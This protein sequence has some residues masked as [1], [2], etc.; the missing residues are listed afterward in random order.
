MAN[1]LVDSKNLY[2]KQHAKQAIAWYPWSEQALRIAKTTDKPI[3][4]S[5]GYA[6]CHWCHMMTEE[7]FN[8]HEVASY[9]NQYFIAIKV[10]REQRP[11]I[12]HVY[13]TCHQL[14]SGQS[15]GWPLNLFLDPKNQV[16]F[17]SGTYFPLTTKYGLP[18]FIDVL[19][20]VHQFYFAHR[21]TIDKQCHR[22]QFELNK[23][24][25][26]QHTREHEVINLSL[27][28][29]RRDY[30]AKIYDAQ[31]GGFGDAPK[32]AQPQF[33]LGLFAHYQQSLSKVIPDEIALAMVEKTLQALG[34]GGLYDHVEGGFFRYSVDAAWHIP[35]FE[36]MLYD[37]ASLL[38]VYSQAYFI[39][40]KPWYRFVA[41]R[42]N[43]WV[44]SY[45]YCQD[46][47]YASSQ[48][49]DSENE[50]GRYYLWS[51]EMLCEAL[52][53]EDYAWLSSYF[54]LTPHDDLFQKIHLQWQKPWPKAV[55]ERE[56][57]ASFYLE[58]QAVMD[59]LAIMRYE[60]KAPAID[61]KLLTSWNALYISALFRASVFLSESSLAKQGLKVL[62]FIET[63]MWHD[64]KLLGYRLE[65][66]TQL[67]FL[68]DYA[69][70]LDAVLLSLQISFNS[71]RWDFALSL[72]EAMITYFYE[73]NTE[74][75]Y[76]T[77]S[78]HHETL[79]YRDF[80]DKDDALPS[81]AAVA[82]NSL[83]TLASWANRPKWFDLAKAALFK[84]WPE[85]LQNPAYFYTWTK[86][87]E[88]FAS[89]LPKLIIRGDAAEVAAWQRVCQAQYW[90]KIDVLAIAN[91]S[92]LPPLWTAYQPKGKVSA[93]YC[94]SKGCLGPFET[95][96]ALQSSI[97]PK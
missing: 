49:A 60:R 62:N 8:D 90:E 4:L 88:R 57:L 65:D 96:T 24:V 64:D 43:Q 78:R 85:I 7:V 12:D 58:Y 53:A 91:E 16:P 41:L 34:H 82:V 11:D 26:K 20:Q 2:L 89:P 84:V 22:L 95:L 69:Y 72:A 9:L 93:W 67:G 48:D 97:C 83:L 40:K 52:S 32:F 1:H 54:D 36:K 68:S 38:N 14:L 19:K 80:Q 6:A 44:Q 21:Q 74:R 77:S 79:I 29:N 70:L 28:E 86:A 27:I 94:D 66:E 63:Q 50:E 13:L 39:T 92:N 47:A 81:S 55:I 75:F 35:H 71:Q 37:Q 23:L 46:K 17:Y 30:L 59:K 10:D 15:G 33:L 31:H 51:K 5:I 61:E 76:E 42:I 73:P 25:N 45:L 87:S 56:Q 18:A 3:F